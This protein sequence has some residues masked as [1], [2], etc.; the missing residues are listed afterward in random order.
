MDTMKFYHGRGSGCKSKSTGGGRIWSYI[1]LKYIQRLNGHS[2]DPTDAST[3]PTDN[4]AVI[5]PF[6]RLFT[7][8]LSVVQNWDVRNADNRVNSLEENEFR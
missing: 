3:G 2:T 5:G 4:P 1:Q 6:Q 7:I 8:A